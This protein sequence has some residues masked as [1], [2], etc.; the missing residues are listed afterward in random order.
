MV[1]IKRKRTI[2]GRKDNTG[3]LVK[4]ATVIPANQDAIDKTN[5]ELRKKCA[6]QK[7]NDADAAVAAREM[8]AGCTPVPIKKAKIV[9]TDP[10]VIS[11]MNSKF[12]KDAEIQRANYA[13]G[14]QSA[15]ELWAGAPGISTSEP[16]GPTL[17]KRR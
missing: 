11:E 2:L 10:R 4:G 13:A 1:V 15:E 14:L 16:N 3:V 6:R 12:R 9:P 8:Y 17:K 5:A 7:S